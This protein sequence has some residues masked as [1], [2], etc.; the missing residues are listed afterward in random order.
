MRVVTVRYAGEERWGV[1][2]PEGGFR[3]APR[4]PEAPATVLDHLDEGVPLRP[5]D[6]WESVPL[7]DATLLAPIPVPRRNVIC[8]GLNYADHAEES[9]RAKGREVVLPEHPVVFTKA[10]TS[11][12]GP[13][14]EIVL[15]PDVTEQMDWE[16]ELALVMGR[17]GRHIAA[18]D[19]L[20]HV[21]GYTIINDL[22]A[23]D[24]QFR[25]KQFFLGKSLDSACPMGPWITT[26]DEVEDP[27]ALDIRCRVNGEMKQEAN[28]SLMIFGIART[29]E[30][31]SGIL[32]L[33]P[34]DII[35]T[36]TPAGVGFARTPPQY[37]RPGDRVECEIAGLGVLRN[38][39][40]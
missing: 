3:L 14:S 24:L 34:G 25:H 4:P 16:V 9:M 39:F 28:T 20:Q 8:M 10:T 32:R 23:R 36:G 7:E 13:D 21:F 31:L 1:L 11:V 29:I 12:T 5:G 38:Y 22:S 17:G 33:Q 35:A 40:I 6:D 2:D 30:I 19:A 27:Q 26:V 15:E 18:A 37:L